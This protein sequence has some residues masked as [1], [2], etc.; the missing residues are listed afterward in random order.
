MAMD[1]TFIK[2]YSKRDLRDNRRGASDPYAL[3]GRDGR[4]Y[5]LGYKAHISADVDSD[6]PLAFIAASETRRSMPL[7]SSTRP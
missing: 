5:G 4:T 1:T 3:V 6:L 7:G 2:A